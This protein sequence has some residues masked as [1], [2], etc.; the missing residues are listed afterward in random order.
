VRLTKQVKEF[1]S[2]IFVWQLVNPSV[3]KLLIYNPALILL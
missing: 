1:G 2:P 3:T